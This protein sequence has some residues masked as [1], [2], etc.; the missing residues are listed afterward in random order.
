[1]HYLGLDPGNSGA[2]V[3]LKQKTVVGVVSWR[4][5][6]RKKVKV[7]EVTCM[8]GQK[9]RIEIVK[10]MTGVSFKIVAM[11]FVLGGMETKV[12]IEEVYGGRNIRT[13]LQLA[14]MAGS[15]LGP[16]LHKTNST[17]KWVHA[18]VWRRMVFGL[19]SNTPR[20]ECK[21]VSKHTIPCQLPS[22]RPFIEAMGLHDHITDAAGIAQW[23]SLD[24]GEKD[25][26]QGSNS[27]SI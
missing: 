23:L 22:I 27:G 19:K 5:V 20:A 26:E 16:I 3:L 13:S 6:V 7:Y 17:G 24:D 2:A 4:R 11:L 9:P 21:E 25:G 8:T 1:M 12:A 10:T 14:K 15:L 18:G